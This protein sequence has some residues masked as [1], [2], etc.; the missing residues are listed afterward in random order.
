[1]TPEERFVAL[2]DSRPDPLA[3]VDWDWVFAMAVAAVF[4]VLFGLGLMAVILIREPVPVVAGGA[5]M[6]WSAFW[7]LRRALLSALGQR[8]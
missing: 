7:I 5:A 8:K 6:A 1:M 2:V 4:S 3:N